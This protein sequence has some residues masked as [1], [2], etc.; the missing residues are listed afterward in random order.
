MCSEWC[1]SPKNMLQ[2][3]SNATLLSKHNAASLLYIGAESCKK[4][5]WSHLAK[6]LIKVGLHQKIILTMILFL[7]LT[8]LH[9]SSGSTVFVG[10]WSQFPILCLGKDEIPLLCLNPPSP[11]GITSHIQGPVSLQ[12]MIL[13]KHGRGQLWVNRKWQSAAKTKM[14]YGRSEALWR[15]GCMEDHTGLH[16]LGSMCSF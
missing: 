12:S 8:Q 4:K 11:S 2:L 9:L 14:A 16:G 5:L 10:P 15:T 6:C 13:H 3:G 7:S 1:W